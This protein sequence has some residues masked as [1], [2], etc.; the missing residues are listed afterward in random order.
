M[1]VRRG[2]TRRPTRR[3]LL[4]APG[5]CVALLGLGL[6]TGA[7]AR[8]AGGRT[9]VL[10]SYLVPVGNAPAV[11]PNDRS[12]GT[13]PAVTPLH[14]DVVLQPRDPAAMQAAA[15]DVSTPGNALYKHFLA[16]GQFAS[17]FGPT[18][19]AIAAVTAYLRSVGLTP[20]TITADHLIIPVETT[21]GRV[22]SALHISMNLYRQPADALSAT[23]VVNA[24]APTLPAPLANLVQGIIGLDTVTSRP[25][26]PIPAKPDP[27]AEA[28]P[29]VA[30]AGAP[31]ACSQAVTVAKDFGGWTENQLAQAY[32]FDGVFAK[33]DLGSGATIA[34]FE[35]QSYS[36]K[37]IADFQHCYGTKVHITNV[38]VNHAK[39]TDFSPEAALDIETVIGLAPKAALRVYETSGSGSGPIDGYDA[40]VSQDKAQVVSSSWSTAPLNCDIF[41]PASVIK[42]ENSIFKEAA[43]QG[44]S[45]FVADGDVGSEGCMSNG[46]T[47]EL[48]TPGNPDAI[49]VNPA[50]HTVY[51]ANFTNGTITVLDENTLGI[52]KTFHLPSASSEPDALA[53]DSTTNQLWISEFGVGIVAEVN[54]STCDAS[55]VT[56][57]VSTPA[58]DEADTDPAGI[59]VDPST[60]TV[61]VALSGATFNQ[62]ALINEKTISYVVS[63]DGFNRP[64]AVAV[65]VPSDQVFFTVAG[66]D[67]AAVFDGA[68]CN[69]TNTSTCTTLATGAP[70]GLDPV[71]IAVDAATEQ[72]YVANLDSN[73]VTVISNGPTKTIGL[74]GLVGPTSL[75]LAPNGDGVLVTAIG[76]KPS[77]AGVA[78]ISNKTNAVTRVISGIDA[79]ISIASDPNTGSSWVA[80]NGL[81]S[82]PTANRMLTTGAIKHVGS[83]AVPGG[84]V[85]LP[86][87]LSVED[88]SGQP[89]VTGVGGTNL[90]KLGPAPKESVWDEPLLGEGAGT[91]G[92]SSQWAMPSYQKGPG[93]KSSLS[94]NKPCHAKAGTDCREL[95][96]VSASA[97]PAHGYV[98]VFQGSWTVVGG[99]SAATPL[100]AALTALLDVYR[101]KLHR[102]GFLNPALYKLAAEGKPV[103]NDV[104]VGNN[105]YTTTNGGLYP[106]TKRYDMATGLG[107]PIVTALAKAFG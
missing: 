70:V 106:T 22:D 27:R 49:A 90:I 26:G 76:T 52:V 53:V 23:A 41:V 37:D 13:A 81:S 16:R 6:I 99:T 50:T 12:L 93:V 59:A 71:G 105:D 1:K 14:I 36:S 98:I 4:V 60:G 100:W 54:G 46:G 38:I 28:I 84:I 103:L 86:L 24:E 42:A 92:I 102:L 83:A 94:S 66:D 47:L 74:G 77:N 88:P 97:D 101:G 31:K 79:P 48:N 9:A 64:V 62:I 15:T 89:F 51:A 33:G 63:T 104:T 72:L 29:S 75:A 95:P 85:W 82:A 91:G 65:D 68:T 43:L 67:D 11:P 39:D 40:I 107:T 56:D 25:T 19:R 34:L 73:N 57:C 20:G 58:I 35:E 80:D 30:V 10:T 2:S 32:S 45:V 5:V 55:T 17:V 87:V 7:P 69:A 18:P 78:V 61:Y 8:S 44:Q 21:V 96:D 3:Q